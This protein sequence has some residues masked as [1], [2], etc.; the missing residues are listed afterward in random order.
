[1]ADDAFNCP[2]KF[3][4]DRN[5]CLKEFIYSVLKQPHFTYI[6]SK[7][8]YIYVQEM[9]YDNKTLLEITSQNGKFTINQFNTTFSFKDIP[10]NAEF[11]LIGNRKKSA[12]LNKEFEK[13]KHTQ[14]IQK[15]IARHKKRK[16]RI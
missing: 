8:D 12:Q 7:D 3:Q 15:S 9:Y 6:I 4:V 11:N 5:L 16:N 10:Q 14:Q 13:E 2:Q 1:M